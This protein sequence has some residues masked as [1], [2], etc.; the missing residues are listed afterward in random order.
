MFRSQKQILE[1][2]L[3]NKAST[4]ITNVKVGPVKGGHLEKEKRLVQDMDTVSLEFDEEG[5]KELIAQVANAVNDNWKSLT[6]TGHRVR[7]L[8]TILGKK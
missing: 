6:I 2:R 4:G 3:E 1:E 7:N 8:V 5:I